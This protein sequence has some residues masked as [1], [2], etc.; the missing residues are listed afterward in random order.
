MDKQTLHGSG[1]GKGMGTW[2]GAIWHVNRGN[3]FGKTGP[4]VW[5]RR[6][7]GVVQGPL[8]QNPGLKL[9][10]EQPPPLPSR[11]GCFGQAAELRPLLAG[12]DSQGWNE[13]QRPG[14]ELS[15]VQAGLEDRLDLRLGWGMGTTDNTVFTKIIT[16]INRA[17]WYSLTNNT[18]Q[19]PAPQPASS[20]KIQI[21]LGR[22][23]GLF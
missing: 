21:C 11:N 22:G 23:W 7:G 18:V 4:L 14:A 2:A 13:G 8:P 15:E 9:P 17:G 1:E 6:K 20:R 5:W 12:P 3:R 16:R 10:A 19:P